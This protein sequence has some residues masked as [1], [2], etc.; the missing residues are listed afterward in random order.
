VKNEV[1]RF[2]SLVPDLTDR[3]GETLFTSTGTKRH[4][5]VPERG[6]NPIARPSITGLL[7]QQQADSRSLARCNELATQGDE[8]RP[9]VRRQLLGEI[10]ELADHRVDLVEVVRD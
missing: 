4:L 3:H 8:I 2:D 9:M 1:P 6:H 10:V 7:H 5:S